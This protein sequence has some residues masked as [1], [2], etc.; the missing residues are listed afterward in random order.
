MSSPSSGSKNKPGKNQR[1]FRRQFSAL[2]SW[3]A[4]YL[5]LKMEPICSSETSVE[6]QRTTR[7]YI[8]KNRNLQRKQR[9]DNNIIF[10]ID[11]EAVNILSQ[12]GWYA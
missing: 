1:E 10:I 6:L 11:K 3:V 9:L 2:V 4:C 12:V 7:S 8:P 5:T